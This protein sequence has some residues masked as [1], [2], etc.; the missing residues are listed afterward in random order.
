[1]SR[2]IDRPFTTKDFSPNGGG[3]DFLGLRWVNLTI[4]GTE[5]IPELNNV[6]RDM[7]T[8]MLAAWIPWKFRA[9]CSSDRD[10]TEKNYR[11]FREKAETA[12]ALTYRTE[13]G[14]TRLHGDTRNRIG[15]GQT[16]NLPAALSFAGVKRSEQT[17]LYAAAAYGP[18]LG[19]LGLIRT[20][21]SIATNRTRLNIPIAHDDPETVGMLRAV[22]EHLC[23]SPSYGKLASLETPSFEW[24]DIKS[25]GESGLDPAR[26]RGSEFAAVKQGF[27][28][29]LLP[30]DGS[31]RGFMR[32]R[33]A[34]L[35]LET[36]RQQSRLDSG[37]LRI[38][39]Y[40]GYLPTGIRLQFADPDTETHRR[41]WACFLA[42]QYQRYALER[43]L[44]CFEVAVVSGAHSIEEVVEH[45]REG[46]EAAGIRLDQTLDQFIQT[47]AG[48]AFDT[49]EAA[50]SRAWNDTVHGIDARFE[51]IAGS[52]AEAAVADGLRM[53]GGW[54]WRMLCRLSDSP[55][56]S[57]L[58]LG[59]S[60]RLGMKWF[61]G[62][63]AERRSQSLRGV[64]RDIFSDLVF[65]QHM[66]VAL[67]RFDGRA[68]RLRFV[69]G[70]SGIEP[71]ESA[72]GSLASDF[73]GIMPDR[74]ETLTELLC[75]TDVLQAQD[76]RVEIGPAAES[77]P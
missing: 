57:L 65:S 20:Y 15:N 44:W 60:D 66:R 52:K 77:V 33:T 43:F 10:Y 30:S 5:L 14:L 51:H 18:A 48:E 13:S 25:L 39:W 42:R 29:R 3:I 7:G 23:R 24:Q 28:K 63:L 76:G 1:M 35:L 22:D 41:R 50:T 75:D 62:W 36:L 69:L 9:L 67:S 70:D 59:G 47:L 19:A 61:M 74:L 34:R 6:T 31:L 68:Q 16:P 21:H 49:D 73:V 53:I 11:L 45:W 72:R 40:T 17:T 64:L 26:L 2:N 54:Y 12:L 38:A 27:L 37:Q 58:S 32:T 55:M 56:N 8:F 71:T 4:V 46:T